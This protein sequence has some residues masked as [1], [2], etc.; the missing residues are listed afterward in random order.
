LVRSQ[1]RLG[2]CVDVLKLRITIAGRRALER[3]AAL[4]VYLLCQI[5]PDAAWHDPLVKLRSTDAIPDAADRMKQRIGLLIVYL[6]SEAP[7][8]H[9]DDVGRRIEMNIPYMLEKHGTRHDPIFVSNQ[10]FEELEFAGKKL[11][12]APVPADAASDAI[13]FEIANTQH[14]LPH[15]GGAAPRESLDPCQQFRKGEG[16]DEI[17]VGMDMTERATSGHVA[18]PPSPAMNSRRRRPNL[19]CPSRRP[20]GVIEAG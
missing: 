17:S 15:Y 13:D 11:D 20:W 12:F 2:L 5:V 19:I 8:I 9:I 1:E 18:A 3:D 14:R 4:W 10:I 16:L 6:A 7:D